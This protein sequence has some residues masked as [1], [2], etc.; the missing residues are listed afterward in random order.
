M[1]RI[2]KRARPSVLLKNHSIQVELTKESQPE[3]VVYVVAERVPLPDKRLRDN[4]FCKYCYLSLSRGA[5][6]SLN[7]KLSVSN[8]IMIFKL[9][10]K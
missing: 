6:D 10:N 5:L 8:E 4:N 9:I 1:R 3:T 2:W 7:L